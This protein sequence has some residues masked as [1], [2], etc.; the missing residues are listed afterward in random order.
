M[1]NRESLGQHLK[2]RLSRAAIATRIT[3]HRE[4]RALLADLSGN[5]GRERGADG[6]DVVRAAGPFGASPSLSYQASQQRLPHSSRAEY[7]FRDPRLYHCAQP[8]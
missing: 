6:A 3:P 7:I 2:K 8:L 1:R 4:G 5:T